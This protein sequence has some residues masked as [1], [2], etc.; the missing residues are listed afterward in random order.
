MVIDKISKQFGF[1][2]ETIRRVIDGLLLSKK[3]LKMS[4][5]PLWKLTRQNNRITRRPILRMKLWDGQNYLGWSPV[6]LKE[7][8]N[9]FSE[10]MIFGEL[11]KE[12][13]KYKEV[14]RAM[15]KLSLEV[16]TWFENEFIRLM[17][18]RKFLGR[19]I[20]N[21]IGNGK[22]QVKNPRG[23]IDFLG[24][25]PELNLLLVA[26]CK[27]T[28]WSSDAGD[29]NGDF[30]EFIRDQENPTK[31]SHFDKLISKYEW[32]CE[33]IS[34][35]MAALKKEYPQ[36]VCG[37]SIRIAS[38]IVTYHPMLISIFAEDLPLRSIVR[39]IEDF[40]T[41]GDWPY[42]FGIVEKILTI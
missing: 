38:A 21:S 2:Q 11:P 6:I 18:E 29:A 9:H 33:N 28:K 1:S 4:D 42:E 5:T 36:I 22:V 19:G 25:N 13:L 10:L 35:V 20:T 39:F 3:K 26:E 37:D 40:D 7:I 14:K 16:S 8:L 41:I 27:L 15:E 31:K 24:F 30:R 32:V 12:W 34:S 17:S 23:Q